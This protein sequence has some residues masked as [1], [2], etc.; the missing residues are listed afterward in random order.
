MLNVALF[1]PPGA[2]KGTQAHKLAKKYNLTYI[3]TGEILRNEIA[4]N[5]EIGRCVKEKIERGELADDETIVQIIENSIQMHPNSNGILFDGFPRTYAQAYILEGLLLKMNTK[6]SCLISLEVPREDLIS[7]MINRSKTENRPDD[8][9]VVIENRLKE[10]DEKTLPVI[11]FF[12]EQGKYYSTNGLGSIDE[13]FERITDIIEHVLAKTLLNV[14]LFGPPGAGKGTQ[15]KKLAKK[16][17]LE[18]VSTGE[19]IRNEIAKQ[20]EI[21]QIAQPYLESGEVVPDD[22]AIRLI[23]RKLKNSKNIKGFIFKGFPS[24]LVQSYILSGLLKRL[25]SS[26]SLVIELKTTTLQSIKRLSARAKTDKARS[27]DMNTDVIIHRLEVFEKR[28]KKV[29]EFYSQQNKVQSFDGNTD[30]NELYLKLC[31]VVEN[32]FKEIRR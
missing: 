31:E 6:L 23:E 4:S 7:R 11:D 22:I 29:L 21:G 19:M 24:T 12:K 30:E 2:G 10:Y 28:T 25:D 3:S 8:N 26:V 1:G 18:Y 5:T 32:A 14:V 17:N 16:F 13:V 9:K 20:S 15:A 27:Y